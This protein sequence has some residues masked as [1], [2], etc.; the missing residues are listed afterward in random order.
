MSAR[1]EPRDARRYGASGRRRPIQRGRLRR[2]TAQ[3]VRTGRLPA[4]VLGAGLAVL[5]FGI[6]TST[7]FTVQTVTIRGN[8]L[9]YA[10]SVV[11]A[12]GA[13]GQPIFHL[14][15]EDVATRVASHPAVASAEVSAVLPDQVIVRVVERTPALVWQTGDRAVV[16]D[17][18]G[19]VLAETYDPELPRVFQARGELPAVGSR[20]EAD[21]VAA[22]LT[23]YD[24]YGAEPTIE[25]HQTRGIT[26]HLT[27]EQVVVLGDAGRLPLKLA[28]VDAMRGQAGTWARLDV[29]DP[30]RPSYQ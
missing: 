29:R 20:L 24:T 15:T 14:D 12:S 28:V 16:A 23:L 8:S 13:L 9:A 10:D 1:G 25:Y 22:A 2:Y 5:L 11:A 17:Q 18:Y 4:L 3:L 26:L 19:W 30:D 21:L 7:D 6:V 27:N